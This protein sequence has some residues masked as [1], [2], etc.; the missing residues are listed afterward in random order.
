[1][2]IV[3]GVTAFLLL[4]FTLPFIVRI[5]VGPTIFDRVQA[6]IGMGTLITILMIVIGLVYDRV[7]MFVDIALALLLLNLFTTLLIARYVRD[8][9]EAEKEGACRRTCWP[10]SASASACSSCWWRPS[11]SCG[12]LTSSA[13]CTSRACWIRWARRSSCWAP[14]STSGTTSSR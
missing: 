6:L 8:K 12:C 3:F 14:R 11:A 5:I 10:A 2:M 9:T 4:A 13:D 7:D 1:M